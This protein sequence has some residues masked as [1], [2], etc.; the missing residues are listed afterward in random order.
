[1]P[2]LTSSLY[3]ALTPSASAVMGMRYKPESAPSATDGY[4][5]LPFQ[6]TPQVGTFHQHRYD[7]PFSK[8]RQ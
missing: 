6:S 2:S 7:A 1:M 5:D 8:Q 4:S 3:I